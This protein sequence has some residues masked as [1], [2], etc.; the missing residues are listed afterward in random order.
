MNYI[1]IKDIDSLSEWVAEALKIK[2][3]PRQHKKLG[4]NKTL[5]MLFFNPSL[6]TRLSTQKAALQLGMDVMVMK[7]GHSNLKMVPS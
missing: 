4:K 2:K 6:R 1:S 7:D 3:K 5:G